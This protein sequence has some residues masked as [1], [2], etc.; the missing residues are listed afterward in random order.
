MMATPVGH[1]LAGYAIYRFL[2]PSEDGRSARLLVAVVTA[3]APD[4][5]FVPG[6]LVGAPAT[7]H[8]GMSHSL[9]F[10]AAAGV[11]GAVMLGAVT[12]TVARTGFVLSFLCY[13]SHLA[14][15]LFGPDARPPYGIPLFW[16]LT[17]HTF[18]SPVPLLLGAQHVSRTSAS[19]GDWVS[20]VLTLHNVAALGLEIVVILPCVLLAWRCPRAKASR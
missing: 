19:T 20:A 7:Y 6:I 16:P 4:L 14:L 10:A 9:A 11:I 18:L 13:S 17:D 12:G 5:D 8:Q 2:G 3:N 1:S 15:D